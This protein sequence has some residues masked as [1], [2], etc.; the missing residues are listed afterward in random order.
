MRPVL[1][2]LLGLSGGGLTGSGESQ[3]TGGE[4]SSLGAV[5][6]PVCRSQV[7]GTVE[8]AGSGSPA[9]RGGTPPVYTRDSMAVAGVRPNQSEAIGANPTGVVMERT[10]PLADCGMVEIHRCGFER[11]EFDLGWVA[12]NAQTFTPTSHT[13]KVM[14]V[15][16]V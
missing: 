15:G 1:S 8:R 11:D 13:A 2:Q 12:R 4:I 16:K 5:A 7:W 10:M 14:Q 6:Q 9:N 3:G